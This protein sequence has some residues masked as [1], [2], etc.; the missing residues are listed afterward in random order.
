MPRL[1][2]A[3][4]ALAAALL[5][6]PPQPSPQQPAPQQ[7]TFRAGV[8]VVTVDVSVARSGEHVEGLQARNFDV[9]DNGVRQK[10]DKVTIEQVPIDAYLV[11]DVS[12]SVAGEKLA[13]LRHAAKAFV[14]G[15][16]AL[17]QVALV[18]FAKEVKIQ[19][20]LTHDFG[21][22]QRSLS[23]IQAGGQTALFDA[24]LKAISLR[25]RNDRRA[26]VLIL[27]DQHDNASEATQKQAIDAAERSDVI[28]YGVLA[29]EGSTAFGRGAMTGGGGF[30]PAQMQF[31]LGFLRSLAD[32]TGGRV[33]RSNP[34][35]PL[36][37]VFEMV[38][39][40]ARTR[41]VITYAPDKTTPGWHKLQVK[42][43]DAKG[44]VVARRGYFV[45]GPADTKRD[46]PPR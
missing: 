25:E 7:P 1:F 28:A 44:D 38:L 41:Y 34:R 27:T 31:Q 2:L 14:D 42:L 45:V 12:G 40:D 32:A 13:Q 35:L 29:D 39:Y 21:M 30:Q 5:A 17:D 23:E 22:F 20:S 33:F 16:T 19:Q 10:I 46:V 26:I 8:D 24:T 36:D 6:S 18:T 4:A 3:Q 11:F 15:L 43:L 9:F 37:E